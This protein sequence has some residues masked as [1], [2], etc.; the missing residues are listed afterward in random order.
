M[1]AFTAAAMATLALASSCHA[2]NLVVHS[3][4]GNVTTSTMYGLMHED[5]NNSGDGGI[6]AELIYNR[7]FQG[8]DMFPVSLDGWSSVSGAA[9][10][11]KNLSTPLSSALPSSVNVAT[12]SKSGKVGFANSGFWGMDVKVQKYTGSFYVKGSYKGLFTASLQSNLTGET[13]GQVDIVS[14]SVDQGWTQHEFILIPFKNA[15]NVNNTFAITFNA[16]VSDLPP[17]S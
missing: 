1:R 8:S 17:R 6:Y 2:A 13:F 5:I 14:K 11:I 10:S 16:A 4:G 3:T 7:A 9:L 12:G 15:P